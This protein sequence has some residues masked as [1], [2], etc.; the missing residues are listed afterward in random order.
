MLRV[1]LKSILGN[2]LRFA[3]TGLAVVLGVTFVSGVFVLTDSIS[4]SF[5]GLFDEINAG[6]AVYVN[7]ISEVEAEI[8]GG[9]GIVGGA[10][11]PEDLIEVIEAVEGVKTVVPFVQALALI[12]DDENVKIG[13]QGPPNFGFSWSGV[14]PLRIAADDGRAPLAPDEVVL[15][16]GSAETLAM[17]RDIDLAALLGQSVTIVLGEAGPRQ[18]TVVGFSTF[19]ETNS[20]LGATTA[21]FEVETA[22]RL[23]G[24]EGLYDQIAI[25][26]APNTNDDLLRDAIGAAINAGQAA[27]DPLYEVLTGAEQ[28]D[29][30]IADV[31]EGLGFLTTAL[32]AFAAIALFVGAFIIVNTFSIVVAQRTREYGLLRA[33]GA[34]G[35]QIQVAVIIE[36]FVVGITAATVGLV[37]G[38]GLAGLLQTVLDAAGI[39][40]PSSGIVVNPR[41]V[42]ASYVVG[43]GVTIVAAI[44]PSRR[45]AR[46]SPIEALRDSGPDTGGA[47]SARR[48]TVGLA[49]GVLGGALLLVGL[50]V[51]SEVSLVGLGMALTFIGVAVLAPHAA[52]PVARTLGAIPAKLGVPGR[53]AQRNAERNPKRTASTAS[54]LMI[55][56]AL[57]AFF[58]IFSSSALKSIDALLEEQYSA[59]FSIQ[60]DSGFGPPQGMPK[61]FAAELRTNDDVGEVGSFSVTNMLLHRAGSFATGGADIGSTLVGGVTVSNLE[62]FVTVGMVEGAALDLTQPST[63][64]VDDEVAEQ[65]SI[66]VGDTITGSFASSRDVELRIV[67]IFA[68]DEILQPAGAWLM[69]EDQLSVLAG[70]LQDLTMSVNAPEGGSPEVTR[71]AI[72]EIAAAYPGVEALNE[73]EVREEARA[74]V[75]GVLNGLT[76]L[77]F[78]AVIIA[79]IGIINTLA[80]SVFERTREIGLLRAVGMVRQQARA[81]IRWEAVIVSVFGALLGIVVGIFFGWSMVKALASAGI[82]EFDLPVGQLVGYVVAAGIA[83]VIA[84]ILPARRAARLDVLDAV[85]SE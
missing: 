61:A 22:Q 70:G 35:R 75:N 54:A 13:A 39:S 7:P 46:I 42:V 66:G 17:R 10:S 32:L 44:S 15:D 56:V 79:V 19:G 48:T 60:V 29:S 8:G 52:R 76:V 49:I 4:R 25:L 65:L 50:L 84:A 11:L 77:L 73:A 12:V 67:G 82:S 40:I 2:K 81:M 1:A 71:A 58:A 45:A 26:S 62:V 5:N 68:N 37:A 33:V 78:L 74:Q 31:Q 24:K 3:L 9:A 38:I 28:N 51:V 57:V 83:G 72:E 69:D 85:T 14:G 47:I 43:V 16:R 21:A 80:L 64:L 27:D 63:V 59:D 41:T 23:F 34:T 55:G 20:L 6:V 30:D 18:F 53:L 36:A